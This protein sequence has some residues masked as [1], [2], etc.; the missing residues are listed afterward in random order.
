ME[1]A[2]VSATAAPLF[3]IQ[4]YRTLWRL[5]SSS[6]RQRP[7]HFRGFVCKMENIFGEFRFMCAVAC[8]AALGDRIHFVSQFAIHNRPYIHAIPGLLRCRHR[9]RRIRRCRNSCTGCTGEQRDYIW[10]NGERVASAAVLCWSKVLFK[11]SIMSKSSLLSI[12]NFVWVARQS[13]SFAVLFHLGICR[14]EFEKLIVWK[15]IFQALL[16]WPLPTSHSV[17][18]LDFEIINYHQWMRTHLVSALSDRRKFRK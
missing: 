15:M 7:I 9:R 18:K 14:S 17:T 4:S 16:L 8:G 5:C 2:N 13:R 3:C 1:W 10:W 11:D 12:Y 6:S